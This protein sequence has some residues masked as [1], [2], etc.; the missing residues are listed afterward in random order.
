M[1]PVLATDSIERINKAIAL[2][3]SDLIHMQDGRTLKVR[4]WQPSVRKGKPIVITIEAMVVEADSDPEAEAPGFEPR[5]VIP[6]H[7][8]DCPC[9]VCRGRRANT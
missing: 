7:G 5:S 4:S 8:D 3:P 6:M 1:D 2:A 9:L